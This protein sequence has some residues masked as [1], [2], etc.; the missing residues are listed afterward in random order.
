M[1]I[2]PQRIALENI[3]IP[4]PCPVLWADMQGGHQVRYCRHC[5]KNVYNLSAMSRAEAERLL[6]EQ[7]GRLCVNFCRRTDGTIVTRDFQP[8][9]ARAGQVRQVAAR[10][11]GPSLLALSLVACQHSSRLSPIPLGD[12]PM[13]GAPVA[14]AASAQP[15]AIGGAAAEPAAKP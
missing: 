7:M 12:I 11:V 6:A 3:D 2:T 15:E 1:T 4:E 5:Q 14:M 8:G 9:P 10:L 13:G